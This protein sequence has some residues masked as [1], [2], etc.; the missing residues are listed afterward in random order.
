MLIWWPAVLPFNHHL[1]PILI[2][3]VNKWALNN[4]NKL[5]QKGDL[6]SYVAEFCSLVAIANV[7]ESHVLTHL[8]NLGLQ[9]SLI[10]AI[11]MME[12]IPN[13][14]NKYITAIMKINSNIDRAKCRKKDKKKKKILVHQEKIKEDDKDEVETHRLAE[15]F[16]C[17]RLVQCQYLPM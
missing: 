1:N 11:H 7:K 6:T 14:F 4:I 16:W 15:D 17:G 5:K 8:F 12:T 2:W 10:Q 3:N 13:D 9:P